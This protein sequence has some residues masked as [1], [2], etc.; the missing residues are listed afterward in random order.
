MGTT[1]SG[2]SIKV[3]ILPFLSMQFILLIKTQLMIVI[4]IVTFESTLSFPV[5]TVQHA[6]T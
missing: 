1:N 3:Q 4:M 2:G 5:S 6:T